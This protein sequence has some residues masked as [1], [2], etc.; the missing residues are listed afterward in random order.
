MV[1]SGWFVGYGLEISLGNK[2][3]RSIVL[4]LIY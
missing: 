2:E 4:N 3:H 1:I